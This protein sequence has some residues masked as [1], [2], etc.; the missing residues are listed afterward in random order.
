MEVTGREEEDVS[1]YWTASRKEVDTVNSEEEAIARTVCRIRFR[2][3]CGSVCSGDIG[4]QP[5]NTVTASNVV[6]RKRV[7]CVCRGTWAPQDRHCL[8]VH[9]I[10]NICDTLSGN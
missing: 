6:W 10:Q 7:I 8:W 9:P 4:R 2:R 5:L 1:S 3:G